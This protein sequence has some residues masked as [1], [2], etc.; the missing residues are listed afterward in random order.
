MIH[1]RHSAIAAVP[2]DVAFA[3]IDD[4]RTVPDWMFGISE[5]SPTGEFDQGLEST[6]DATIHIG[7]AE[8]RSRLE[9]TEWERNRVITLASLDGTA[10]SSTWEFTARGEN[11]TEINVDFAYRLPGGLAGKAL[12]L[13]VE[14]FIET[15]VKNSEV[16]LRNN[17]E[18]LYAKR[19]P[20]PG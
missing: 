2:V 18:E 20:G 6:F 9:V 4:Y 7:P 11:E 13:I 12:E 3:Y 15:A 10:N 8:L 17:L 14:P 1:V 19:A 5:F 16:N